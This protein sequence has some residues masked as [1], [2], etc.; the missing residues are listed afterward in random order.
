MMLT[1]AETIYTAP[2]W[3]EF[4]IKKKKKRKFEKKARFKSIQGV[5]KYG[6]ARM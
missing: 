6:W 1:R 5:R 3:A 2:V 4:F